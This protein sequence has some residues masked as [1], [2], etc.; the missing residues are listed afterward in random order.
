MNK[1]FRPHFCSAADDDYQW[2]AL[3]LLFCQTSHSYELNVMIMQEACQYDS[4]C[5]FIDFMS[6]IACQ[7]NENAFMCLR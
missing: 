3:T 4:Q 2:M 5:I 7:N 6:Q 1:L